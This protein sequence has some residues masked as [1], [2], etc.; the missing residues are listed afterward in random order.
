MTA[1]LLDHALGLADSGWAVFPLSGKVPF[2]GTRG[3]LDASSD[4]D[5]LRSWWLRWPTANIGAPVPPT[6]LVLDVDP[7][8]GGD[9]QALGSLPETLTCWSGREDGGRHLYFLRP[10]GP[11]TSTKLPA[12]I[13][14]KANGYC[15]VPPS[16]HPATGHPYRWEGADVAALPSH[17]RDLLRPAPPKP[18]PQFAGAG[19]RSGQP[20]VDFVAR[21]VHQG[22]N[23]ALYWAARRAA[24]EGILDQLADDLVRTATAV[25]ESERRAAATVESARKAASE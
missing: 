13:D 11:L 18:K 9:V 7:R 10:H 6:L 20:L 17:L 2:P 16:I 15:V 14:L 24:E 19:K 22:V 3:H 12:G 8:N 23:S 25:G 4:P 21:H 5:V 1:T